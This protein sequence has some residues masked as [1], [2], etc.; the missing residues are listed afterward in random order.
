MEEL[1]LISVRRT[2]RERKKS[3]TCHWRSGC[4]TPSS[5]P[6]FWF[7]WT[8]HTLPGRERNTLLL[9]PRRHPF[10]RLCFFSTSLEGTSMERTR[11]RLER[12]GAGCH[13]KLWQP[14]ILQN[15]WTSF[16]QFQEAPPA[17][18]DGNNW[19]ENLNL[20]YGMASET[21]VSESITR[22]QGWQLGCRSSW[23][24][25]W[26]WG[27]GGVDDLWAPPAP[28]F[29]QLC[30]WNADNTVFLPEQAKKAAH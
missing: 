4:M 3:K 17:P 18:T 24:I 25:R 12:V 2:K 9:L 30:K 8:S 10:I 19:Q 27:G 6:F 14:G 15:N 16:V 20:I 21:L 13:T 22:R 29:Q 23:G 11:T 7:R 28:R 5:H 26:G 1:K